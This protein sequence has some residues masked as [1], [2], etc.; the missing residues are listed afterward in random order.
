MNIAFIH[1]PKTAGFYITKY[2]EAN[3]LHDYRLLNSWE[4]GLDRDWDL[5]ELK[6]F[7]DCERSFVHN[8][9]VN[10]PSEAFTLFQGK[11]WKFFSFMRHPGDRLCSLYNYLQ[12]KMPEDVYGYSMEEFILKRV[13]F[14][15]YPMY[16]KEL[17]YFDVFSEEAFANFLRLFF[18]HSYRPIQPVNQSKNLGYDYYCKTGEVSRKTQVAIELSD[19]FKLYELLSKEPLIKL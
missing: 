5:E 4:Q 7:V 14:P 13:D 6:T 11:N 1:I 17:N 12:I 9:L 2:L 16:W 8:H 19:N 10:W 3:V 18:N 15:A